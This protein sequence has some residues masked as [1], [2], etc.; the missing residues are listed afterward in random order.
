MKRIAISEGQLVELITSV[1]NEN[2]KVLK[3]GG[4]QQQAPSAPSMDM[5][6]MPPMDPNGGAAPMD[7]NMGMPPADPNGGMPPMDSNG[8]AEQNPFDSNFDAGVEADEETDPK[9]YIQ[10]LTG[11]L[12][13]S[14][15]SFN[16]ENGP[17]AG[18]SKYVAS[19]IISAA[20]K[21]LDEKAKKE[22]I[23]KINSADSGEDSEMDAPE[24][25]MGSEEEMPPM[26]SAP[27]QPIQESI[28][29][30]KQLEE[31]AF[32]TTKKRKGT[33]QKIEKGQKSIFGGKSF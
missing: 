27:Q 14:L 19:M 6:P 11:K 25:E 28:I 10:Q 7:P 31:L 21:N 15:N 3:V 33:T 17:D 5:A 4:S 13:Q 32:G 2:R 20:C 16:D 24:D 1:L 30:R 12:S 9:H 23:E 22:L 29:T 18:L 8:G 26:D